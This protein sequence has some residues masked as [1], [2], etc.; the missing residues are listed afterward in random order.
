[1]H[2]VLMMMMRNDM[3]TLLNT[4]MPTQ[5]TVKPILQTFEICHI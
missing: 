4:P 1:M 2:G 5:P 3:F